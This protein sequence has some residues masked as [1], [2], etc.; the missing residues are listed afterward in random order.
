MKCCQCQWNWCPD[1]PAQAIGKPGPP[2]AIEDVKD[3]DRLLYKVEEALR[4]SYVL[5]LKLSKVIAHLPATILGSRHKASLEDMDTVMK[6][7]ESLLKHKAINGA[8]PGQSTAIGVHELKNV[9]ESCQVH[10]DDLRKAL[11]MAAP[12][13]KKVE[14]QENSG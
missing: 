4:G 7:R 12:L 10:F 1:K 3:R 6:E 5:S 11:D 13:L 9:L 8:L 14:E 2:L